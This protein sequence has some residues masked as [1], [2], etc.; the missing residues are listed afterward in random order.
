MAVTSPDNIRTPDSGDQY[1]LVQDLGVL[2]D[3]T[4]AAITKRGNLFVGTAAQRTA[5]TTATN[6]MNWQD[7]DGTAARYVRVAGVWVMQGDKAYS[8]TAAQRTAFTTAPN[9]SLW[10]D[11]DGLKLVY[12]RDGATW[13]I[14]GS[15]LL[16]EISSS[17]DYP[18]TSVVNFLTLAVSGLP[19]STKV[20]VSVSS[21]PMYQAAAAVS[22]FD[23]RYTTNGTVPTV[24]STSART[25]RAYSVSSAVTGV[26]GSEVVLT[27][28]ASGTLNVG[29]FNT[30]GSVYG[31]DKYSM[32]L[33]VA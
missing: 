6:G 13:V 4:Q 33:R 16:A 19:T 8:G 29:L 31:P 5:F 25:V 9:G 2:A 30:L 21:I 20:V 1:A 26:G 23:I 32:S 24:A 18:S 7:T 28:T 11:T 14:T 27:T 17:T 12:K 10:T 3:T 22:A 15:P